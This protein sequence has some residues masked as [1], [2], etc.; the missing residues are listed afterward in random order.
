MS[1]YYFRC[2]INEECTAYQYKPTFTPSCLLIYST[3]ADGLSFSPTAN[4]VIYIKGM[5]NMYIILQIQCFISSN[6]FI[7]NTA[8]KNYSDLINKL[9]GPIYT[10]DFPNILRLL[11][12]GF[13]Y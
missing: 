7:V 11:R 13:R 6:S 12:D 8:W 4:T 5:D 2:M 9:L 10:C 1:E 3:V